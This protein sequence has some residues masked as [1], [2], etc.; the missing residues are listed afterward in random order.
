MMKK[1]AFVTYREVR[2]L[3]EDDCLAVEFL[4]ARGV[5]VEAV[6]WDASDAPWE[7]FDLIV[8]RS[9]WEYHHR[10]KEFLDWVRLMEKMHFP[11]VNP[12]AVIRAN[13]DK[14][15][16]R[17]L[18]LRGI[19]IAP[20]IWLEKG[21]TEVNLEKKLV[22]QNWLR[23]VVK[24]T[25]SMSAHQ[26]WITAP[27]RAASDEETIKNILKTS[28]VMIQKFI[29]E[30]QTGGEWSFVFFGKKISHA[31]LKRPKYG[32]FRVQRDFGGYLELIKPN[33]DLVAQAQKIVEVV[34]E[35]LLYARV[36]GLEVAGQLIL[37]ELELIDPVLFLG[38]D[39]SSL[40]RFYEALKI[41]YESQR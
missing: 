40:A 2:N 41:A 19:S 13:M 32:D 39:G 36:D 14:I 1:V 38:T 17:E 4:K 26:T 34:K 24:P 31:V 9:C 23:A 20:T 28:G 22:N 37:M 8:L 3:T 12:P 16:L 18:E 29:P 27:S 30:V 6:L 5:E 7:K 21:A 33:D 25:V 35:P 11:L 15:Y 10:T